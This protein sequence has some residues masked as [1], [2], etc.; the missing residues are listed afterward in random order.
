M[1]QVE[2]QVKA[3]GPAIS[4]R[5][6]GSRRRAPHGHSSPGPE[7]CPPTSGARYSGVPQNVFIV[8]ASVIPSLQSPKSVIFMWPSLSSIKFSNCIGR[9]ITRFALY[10]WKRG[11]YCSDTTIECWVRH[12]GKRT[13]LWRELSVLIN[14]VASECMCKKKHVLLNT[15]ITNYWL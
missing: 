15:S 7:R 13:Q 6:S 9:E 3:V 5:F 4:G 12:F 10:S 1:I 2:V 14:P 8:A 11:K